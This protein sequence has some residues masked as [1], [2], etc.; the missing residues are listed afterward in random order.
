MILNEEKLSSEHVF[1]GRLLNIY[2]DTVSLPN[3]KQSTREVV[4][5]TGGVCVAALTENDELLFVRQYRYAVGHPTLELPAG[6]LILG[7]DPLEE[8]IRELKEE[9]GAVGV[10]Y[11]DL[12]KLFPSPGYCGEI[13]HMYFCHV[14]HFEETNFDEDEFIEVEKIPIDKAVYMVLNGEIPDAKTQ[15]AVLKT[16]LFLKMGSLQK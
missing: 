15:T 8:G 6:T 13:I 4:A 11:M 7:E 12:G 14:D 5:H 2:K 3:G 16:Y 1:S 10:G 9:T